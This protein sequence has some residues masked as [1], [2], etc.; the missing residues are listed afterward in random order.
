MFIRLFI[1]VSILLSSLL[2]SSQFAPVGSV[3]HYNIGLNHP[4]NGFTKKESIKD[5]LIL[6]VKLRKYVQALVL[7]R[8]M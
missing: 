8:F 7:I 6:G 4:F 2:S 1:V 3:W 5:T